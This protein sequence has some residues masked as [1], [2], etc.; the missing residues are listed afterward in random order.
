MSQF[1]DVLAGVHLKS[2]LLGCATALCTVACHEPGPSSGTGKIDRYQL[3]RRHDVVVRGFDSMSSVSVGN[4][5]FAFTVD[6]TGLQSFPEFYQNGVSLG[7]ESQWGWHS[8]PNPAHYSLKDVTRE[9][10]VHGREVPYVTTVSTPARGKAASDWLRENPHRLDLGLIGWDIRSQAD[11]RLGRDSITNIDQRLNLWE[12]TISSQFTAAG[13]P[14]KVRTL[15]IQDG[16]GI[17][18]K[19]SSPLFLSRRLRVN[20]RFSYGSGAW[21]NA[22]DWNSPDKHESLVIDSGADHVLIKRI[23]DSTVYFVQIHWEGAAGWTQLKRHEF[24]LVPTGKDS[25]LAFSCVFSRKNPLADSGEKRTFAEADTLNQ[26]TWKDFWLS[27]GAVDFS[28]STDPRAAELERRVVLSEY[29]TRI[30]SAGEYP[31]QE[32][33]LTY[34]SWYGKFH[35]EMYLWHEAQFALWNRTPLVERSLPWY[36][37]IAARGRRTALEQG[38][39]GIR[40]PKMTDPSGRESP[41]PIGPFLIWQEPHVIFMSE[42]CYRSHPD[43][44]T[45][46]KY[47]DIVF[48]TAE[49]MAS[50]PW[51]DSV[52]GKYVLGP[53]LIPAQERF[54]RDSTVNPTFELAYWYW[55]LSVAQQWRERLGMGRDS[56]WDSVMQNLSPLPVLGGVYLAAQSF[57]DTYTNPRYTT[58]HPTML[59]AYGLLPRTPMVDTAVVRATLEKVMKVWDW[60]GTWGWDYPMIAMTATRLGM[61]KLAIDV[62]MMKETKNTYLPDGH[63]YQRDNLRIYLPGNGSLLMAVAMMCAGWDGYQGP[64][65]PGFPRDGTWKV[66]WENLSRMP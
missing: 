23:L 25:V 16:D 54:N 1:N 51:R 33:G 17:A 41:S 38:Y 35:L 3:V 11:T 36:K 37:T 66:R 42:L 15:A 27:G 46:E 18:V 21:G 44:A 45:L 53:A 28:G 48:G 24:E 30:Q 64:A 34:N 61:P 60:P 32:T 52:T 22:R 49:F 26:H 10:K 6:P 31:P 19:A 5:N 62:L 2:W 14:V 59:A 8:F 39:K 57:P 9:F 4:G 43:R 56:Q 58:D 50:Y 65:N 12:G 40:W 29:L 13:R 7:T 20:F 63:N 55:G 47:K